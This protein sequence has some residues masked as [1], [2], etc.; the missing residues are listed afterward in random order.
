MNPR[1]AEREFSASTIDYFVGHTLDMTLSE[2]AHQ[3][4]RELQLACEQPTLFADR[5]RRSE[6]IVSKFAERLPGIRELLEGDLR[7]AY[8][9]DPAAKTIDEVLG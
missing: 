9:G 1:L 4:L 3:V 2:L 7:A 5:Q 6:A 8:N